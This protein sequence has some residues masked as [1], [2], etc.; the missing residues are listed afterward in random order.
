MVVSLAQAARD[1]GHDFE[2]FALRNTAALFK[3]AFQARA[4]N[5]LQGEVMEPVVLVHVQQVRDV[6]V[7]NLGQHPCLFVEALHLHRVGRQ[8]GAQHLERDDP[9]VQRVFGAIHGPHAAL[10]ELLDQAVAPQPFVRQR[11]GRM[12]RI[13][14]ARGRQRRVDR[15]GK[16]AGRRHRIAEAPE[17]FERRPD[18]R[19]FLRIGDEQTGEQLFDASG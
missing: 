1:V 16:L 7:V 4:A 17:R 18:R 14:E 2:S 10:A 3:D 19:A 9:A 15:I 12:G 11:L 5:E 8:L 13:G 6:R